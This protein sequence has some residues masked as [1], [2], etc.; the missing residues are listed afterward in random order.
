MQLADLKVHRRARWKLEELPEVARNAILEAAES[1]RALPPEQWPED[2]VQLLDPE[3][4]L[5]LLSAGPVWRAFL[6][7]QEN[8]E[9]EI[10]DVLQQGVLDEWRRALRPNGKRG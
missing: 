3:R 1:L 4:G 6:N 10:S 9:L 5:Y 2:H 8:G 7:R